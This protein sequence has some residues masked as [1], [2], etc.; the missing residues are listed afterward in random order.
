MFHKQTDL[1]ICSVAEAGACTPL[2]AS[3]PGRFEAD[4][5]RDPKWERCHRIFER[6]GWGCRVPG[7]SSRRNLH[8]HHV[9][10]RSHGGCE[11]D[12]NLVVL[13]ATHRQQGIHAGRLRCEGSADGFL[14]WELGVGAGGPPVLT[15]IEDV[16]LT[17]GEGPVSEGAPG[18]VLPS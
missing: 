9:I 13:C 17:E 10:Y 4:A 11:D 14:R 7:C 12:D 1:T 16:L 3:P 5:K 8:A 15:A 6:D 18:R 2:P